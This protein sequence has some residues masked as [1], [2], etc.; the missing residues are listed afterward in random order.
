MGQQLSQE[1]F[2]ALVAP[3][4]K[5]RHPAPGFFKPQKITQRNPA[6]NAVIELAFLRDG[7]V[8]GNA[9]IY[10]ST[11]VAIRGTFSVD[12]ETRVD[13]T[14]LELSCVDDTAENE[15]SEGRRHRR[16]TSC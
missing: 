14:T 9:V 3:V 7:T 10:R 1:K 6:L 4:L 12:V 2:D 5:K 16:R 13:T 8:A 15:T 11:S